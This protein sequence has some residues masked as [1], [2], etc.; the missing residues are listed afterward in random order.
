MSEFKECQNH[1]WSQNNQD[2]TGKC[3]IRCGLAEN[4]LYPVE[5][6]AVGHRIDNDMGDDF[7]IENH[8]SPNCQSRD[9]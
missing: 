7:P 8:I 1:F 4:D 3:C 9:V 6:I 5:E 2:G